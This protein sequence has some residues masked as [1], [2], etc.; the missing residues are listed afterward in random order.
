[1][2]PLMFF[3]AEAQRTQRK[4]TFSFL[5]QWLTYYEACRSQGDA[6]LREKHLKTAWGKRS[7][8]GRLKHYLT[9]Q[10]ASAARSGTTRRRV[11]RMAESR[12]GSWRNGKESKRSRL[13]KTA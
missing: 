9:G 4:T 8:K 6:T 3:R 12:A 13:H 2:A 10:T 7:L 11:S 5:L 1:M